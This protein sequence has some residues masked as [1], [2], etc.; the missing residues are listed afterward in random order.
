MKHPASATLITIHI[1]G[2]VTD[3]NSPRTADAGGGKKLTMKH[4]LLKKLL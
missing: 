3:K 4:I 1:I 2:A